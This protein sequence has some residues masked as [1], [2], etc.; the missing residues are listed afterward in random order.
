MNT[1]E[2]LVILLPLP[3]KCVGEVGYCDTRRLSV[4]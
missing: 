3:S 1:S 2:L 4:C